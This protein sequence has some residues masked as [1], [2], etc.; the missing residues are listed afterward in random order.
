MTT[1]LLPEVRNGVDG[2]E[3]VMANILAQAPFAPNPNLVASPDFWLTLGSIVIAIVLGVVVILRVRRWSDRQFHESDGR[4]TSSSFHEMYE[5]GE[6]TEEE[7]KGI[8]HRLAKKKEG[9]L[10]KTVPPSLQQFQA[11]HEQGTLSDKEYIK[12][13]TNFVEKGGAVNQENQAKLTGES[14]KPEDENRTTPEVS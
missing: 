9:A 12:I 11:M 14:V 5:D 8:L 6:L 13:L 1:P 3:G 10:V 2:Q 4:E 7:Y